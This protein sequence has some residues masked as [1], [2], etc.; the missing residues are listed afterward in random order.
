MSFIIVKYKL[1]LNDVSSVFKLWC[2]CIHTHSCSTIADHLI[3]RKSSSVAH[4]WV[5][6]LAPGRKFLPWRAAAENLRINI[7]SLLK[8]LYFK[9][10]KVWKTRFRH[11][12]CYFPQK[13]FYKWFNIGTYHKRYN[14]STPFMI[15]L[16]SE[17]LSYQN[18]K[19]P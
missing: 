2:I 6:S 9:L 19:N 13:E 5:W 17:L 8:S 3:S 12:S 1:Q 10:W 14:Q 11:I 4:G 16:N 7:W 15:L 18:N